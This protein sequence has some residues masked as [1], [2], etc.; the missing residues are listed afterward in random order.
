MD[1]EVENVGVKEVRGQQLSQLGLV[2]NGRDQL[3][4]KYLFCHFFSF[5]NH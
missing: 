1:I 2:I 5:I 3:V 4:E